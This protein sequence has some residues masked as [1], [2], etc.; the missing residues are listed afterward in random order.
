MPP[1]VPHDTTPAPP[2]GRQ[3]PA[4]QVTLISCAWLE[5]M[6]AADLDWFRPFP[7]EDD[8]VQYFLSDGGG[9]AAA[10]GARVFAGR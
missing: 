3:I 1:S 10:D 4:E 7:T 6:S 5:L 8:A 2:G 9:G